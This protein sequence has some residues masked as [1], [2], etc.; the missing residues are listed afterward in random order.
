MVIF[1]YSLIGIYA[2]LTAIAGVKK[3]NEEG[4]R[5]R[6]LLFF[7]VSIG[8]FL[9]QFIPN[10]DWTFPLLIVAFILLHILAITEGIRKNGQLN[11]NHHII[12]F[13]FHCIIVV[14]VYKYIN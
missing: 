7:I 14:M 10:K 9:I 5:W 2:S 13:L 11:Y 3:W 4:F 12:R 6:Y 1:T 8:V